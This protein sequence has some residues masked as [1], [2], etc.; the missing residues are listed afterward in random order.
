VEKD[1]VAELGEWYSWFAE[2]EAAGRS[3]LYEEIVRGAAGD[4]EFLASLCELPIAKRQPN[5][6]LAAVRYVGGLATDW[7]Q[8][9]DFYFRSCEE[10]HAVMRTRRTQTNEPAR[11]AILLPLLAQLP[12][13]LALL[14]VG[15]AAGLCLLIDRYAYDYGQKRVPPIDGSPD[16]PVF[17]CRASDR[18]PIP[19][20]P[21]DVVWRAGL[22]INPLDV[23]SADDVAW[24][25]T[26]VWPG[27]GRRIELLRAALRLARRDPPRVIKG[28][29]RHDLT[30]LAEQAPK[31]ATL[32]V[33]HCSVLAYVDEPHEREQFGERVLSLGAR[34]VSN[35]GASVIPPTAPRDESQL[36]GQAVLALDRKPIARA[37][38][39]GTWI[40]WL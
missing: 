12:Q 25:E 13:P 29:L 16:A 10:I 33:F 17:T 6:L 8:F 31:D 19:T 1:P 4:H 40:Q 37:D 9:R 3:P 21:V 34:W 11:C 35:E 20:R 5:L 27:E 7:S 15:A 38:M 30:R 24:L 14:E 23:T 26:L 2:H 18:T 22:D 32:V 39:H 28:D 36:A